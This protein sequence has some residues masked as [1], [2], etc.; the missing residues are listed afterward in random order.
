LVGPLLQ[1]AL[2][3]VKRPLAQ[4][5]DREHVF[6][7][8]SGKDKATVI[9]D[10]A[11]KMA[12]RKIIQDKNYVRNAIM[13]RE[14]SM[15]TA[16]GGG[17][18]LPHARLKKLAS[19]VLCFFRLREPIDFDSPDEVPVQL[20]FLEL[21]DKNDDGMQLN[22]ISQ[23]ARFISVEENKKRLLECEREDEIH[24]ILSMDEKD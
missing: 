1:W 13:Q 23:V 10:M 22:L 17:V 6:L 14:E 9:Q 11:R 7:D 18:A 19:P 20:L 24:H 3:G 8:V 2:K 5:F 16:I 15:S 4:Y 12:E 21:T